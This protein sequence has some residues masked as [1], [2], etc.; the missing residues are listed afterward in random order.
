MDTA[1]ARELS[2]I[3]DAAT[4][5]AA[6]HRR[7][8]RLAYPPGI[9]LAVNFTADFDAMLLRRLMN[10]PPMQLAK[11]EFGGRVGIW[12][13][14]ELFDSHAVKA[15][16]FTPGRIAE[17]YP[18]AV[19]AAARAGHE[20]ADHMW[21][22]RVPREPELERDHLRKTITALERLTGRRPV[23]SRSSHGLTLLRDEGFIYVS[24]G[25]GDHL[26]YYV[27]DPSGEATLLN[28]PFHFA[29]DDAMFF[30]FAWMGSPNAA[31]RITDPDRVEE[32]WWDAFLHQYRQG[33]YLNVC[34]HPFVSGRALRIAM[35]DRLIG[36]M[37]T[38]PGVWFPTCEA[39]ARHVIR[40]G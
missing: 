24:E 37:K 34:L 17:L 8:D 9:R 36:R 32:L 35:L 25:S 29:I 1:L 3:A 14:I 22:H 33:G 21:E 11:G 4:A 13:L 28:L 7:I 10:E 15:T 26:P 2:D 12:R 19:R 6:R 30:S 5:Y 31:Q 20:I 18:Q 16:I 39:F 40:A 23:G 27:T 38:L